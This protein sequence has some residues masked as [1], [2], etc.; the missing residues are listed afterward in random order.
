MAEAQA[1]RAPSSVAKEAVEAT[2]GQ[3]GQRVVV[4]RVLSGRAR[5]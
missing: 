2:T 1:Q 3:A 4:V 5:G